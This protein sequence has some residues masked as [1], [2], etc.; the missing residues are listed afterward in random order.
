MLTKILP[1]QL[2]TRQFATFGIHFFIWAVRSNREAN[3]AI[4]KK[5][6]LPVWWFFLPG[7]GYWWMWQYAASLE[8]ASERRIKSADVFLFYLIATSPWLVGPTF[9]TNISGL[10]ESSILLI[11][12]I[13]IGLFILTSIAT[14]GFCMTMIQAKINKL[15]ATSPQ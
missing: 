1:K 2:W 9:S 8:Q 15:P 10:S 7:G 11:F 13:Q 5:D 3:L 14:H 6:V 4:G 12:A